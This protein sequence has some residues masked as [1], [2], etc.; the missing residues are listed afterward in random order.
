M[1]MGQHPSAND[2][3]EALNLAVESQSKC[4][5]GQIRW[6]RAIGL[7]IM[8]SLQRRSIYYR[9][10]SLSQ[11]PITTRHFAAPLVAARFNYRSVPAPCILLFTLSVFELYYAHLGKNKLY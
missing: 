6:P 3:T 4:P 10:M 7:V 2:I 1:A 5:G 9:A 8:T 11:N